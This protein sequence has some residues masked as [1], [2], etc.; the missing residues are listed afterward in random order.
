VPQ[1]ED[2]SEESQSVEGEIDHHKRAATPL[3][4]GGRIRIHRGMDREEAQAVKS[5]N[6]AKKGKGNRAGVQSGEDEGGSGD[7]VRDAEKTE[8]AKKI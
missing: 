2:A 5:G 1:D 4:G 7:V 6:Q 3:S 8:K